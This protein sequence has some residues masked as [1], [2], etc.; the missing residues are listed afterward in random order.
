VEPETERALLE[1][2][3]SLARLEERFDMLVQPILG[4]SHNM[5][6]RELKD[7]LGNVIVAV[8]LPAGTSEERWQE[9]LASYTIEEPSPEV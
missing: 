9:V 1:P 3:E 2:L 8:T 7:S 4:H 5:E 6:T